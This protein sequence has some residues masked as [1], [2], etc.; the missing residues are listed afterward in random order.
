MGDLG[1][2]FLSILSDLRALAQLV[3][4]LKCEALTQTDLGD[5]GGYLQLLLLLALLLSLLAL[6]LLFLFKL[7]SNL[8]K[9]GRVDVDARGA[10]NT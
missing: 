1:C 5:E 8:L 10:A 9:L 6:L 2:L 4:D 7:S 3:Y